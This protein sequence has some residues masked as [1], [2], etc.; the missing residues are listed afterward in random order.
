[1]WSLGSQLHYY[2]PPDIAPGTIIVPDHL[3]GALELEALFVHRLMAIRRE[4]KVGVEDR[5]CR[6][7][8][9]VAIGQFRWS[10]TYSNPIK[11][12]F[13]C[14]NYNTNGKRWCGLFVWTDTGQDEPLEK[15]K[16]YEDNHE[17]KMNFDW[18]LGRR[19]EKRERKKQRERKNGRRE[20][21]RRV[22][23]DRTARLGPAA[24]IAIAVTSLSQRKERENETAIEK[25]NGAAPPS[26]PRTVPPLKPIGTFAV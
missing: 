10:E 20:K 7:G 22:E 9:V 24:T 16:S 23:R 13:S 8:A 5:G 15:S 4:R 14:P 19:K 18:R 21:E 3:S 1:M 25:K 26:P 6:N 11:P 2:S 17:V 12:F